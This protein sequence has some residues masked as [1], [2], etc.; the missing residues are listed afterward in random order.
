MDCKEATSDANGEKYTTCTVQQP[1]EVIRPVV[2]KGMVEDIIHKMYGLTVTEVKELDSY[3]DRNYFVRVEEQHSNPFIQELHPEGYLLKVINSKDS[4]NSQGLG[5]LKIVQMI[6]SRLLKI[7]GSNESVTNLTGHTQD[8]VCV[9]F[10]IQFSSVKSIVTLI[11]QYIICP[12][13]CDSFITTTCFTITMILFHK[14][15]AEFNIKSK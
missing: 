2:S 6:S 13:C 15:C 14:F 10:Q 5:M 4:M 9:C 7:I 11:I 12:F 8:T 1:G 3:D